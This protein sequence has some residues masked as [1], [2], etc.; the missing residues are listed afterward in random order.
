MKMLL[1]RYNSRPN[2]N[3]GWKRSLPALSSGTGL[4]DEIVREMNAF[5]KLFL[6]VKHK[7]H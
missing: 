3:S 1:L 7:Y 2:M 4:A 5:E 6:C